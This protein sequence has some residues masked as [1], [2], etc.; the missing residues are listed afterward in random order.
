MTVS[1]RP[2]T[3]AVE[4]HLDASLNATVTSGDRTDDLGNLIDPPVV[5]VYPID[6]GSWLLT[7]DNSWDD[8]EAPYQLTCVGAGRE[9]AEWL[10]DESR[11]VML[12]SL[13]AGVKRVRPDTTAGVMP[14]YDVSPHVWVA[15]PVYYLTI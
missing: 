7:L 9:Q 13:P 5:V 4:A 14:D 3:D 1:L 12:G 2:V 6:G 11:A 10:A 8:L 15:T